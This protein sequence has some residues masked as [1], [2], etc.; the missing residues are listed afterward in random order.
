M[1]AEALVDMA[2]AATDGDSAGLTQFVL[3]CLVDDPAG[4]EE[5]LR[6]LTERVMSGTGAVEWLGQWIVSC[7]IER[8][9][10]F[11]AADDEA[12]KL[13]ASGKLG[14]GITGTE[15]RSRYR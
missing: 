8:D 1:N 15:L 14:P 9:R 3:D 2:D 7:I 4:T 10:H 12:S 13:V 11:L 6:G 5:F